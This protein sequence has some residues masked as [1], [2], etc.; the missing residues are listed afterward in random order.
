MVGKRFPR[1]KQD[2]N[3]RINL[4]NVSSQDRMKAE[5]GSQHLLR[6]RNVGLEGAIDSL[7]VRNKTARLCNDEFA[8]PGEPSGGLDG[9]VDVTVSIPVTGDKVHVTTDH[10]SA[11]MYFDAAA[12]DVEVFLNVD[13]TRVR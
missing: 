10:D 9:P 5:I 11:V 3:L 4:G 2:L 12:G 1:S 6:R 7:Q 8:P 13:I